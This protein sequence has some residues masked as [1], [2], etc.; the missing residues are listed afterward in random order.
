MKRYKA[1]ILDLDGTTIASRGDSRPSAAVE[2]AIK[3]A[4]AHIKVAVATGRVWSNA[5]TVIHQLGITEPCVLDGGA[6]IIRPT[7]G[8][9]IFDRP[10]S[11][12]KQRQVLALCLPLQ[13]SI[14][15]SVNNQSSLITRLED[16]TE[17]AGKIEIENVPR[18][19]VEAILQKL[20]AI[21]G[22]AIHL[23]SSWQPGDVTAIHVT[24][25]GATK[26]HALTELLKIMDV[27]TADT[28]GVGDYV[29]DLPLFKVVG[30]KVAM[31]NAP[32]ELK[33]AADYIAPDLE[34]DG[35]ADVIRKF[36]L[37]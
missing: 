23:A 26:E 4:H 2:Q 32:A 13:Y 30:L 17:P 14:Y 31:G 25:P 22:I 34:H 3:A 8:Q 33:A 19:A 10:L 9:I 18:P 11:V 12:A 7:N 37:L 15:A 6:R 27:A 24:D 29:N 5:E 28:I 35:V 36:I 21:D 1:L 20:A 16:A